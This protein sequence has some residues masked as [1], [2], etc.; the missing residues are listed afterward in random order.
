MARRGT[1]IFAGALMGLG[2]DGIGAALIIKFTTHD[3]A[4]QP[5]FH[6]GLGVGLIPMAMSFLAG[7]LLSSLFWIDAQGANST[8]SF[9]KATG[10]WMIIW[11]VAYIVIQAL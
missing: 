4:T 7:L 9:L 10:L 6:I 3:T 2:L 1:A 8:V 11:E 5:I